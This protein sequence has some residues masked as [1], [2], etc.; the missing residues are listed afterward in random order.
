MMLENRPLGVSILVTTK[1]RFELSYLMI[2]IRKE[3]IENSISIALQLRKLFTES[4]QIRK[5]VASLA[6]SKS[7]VLISLTKEKRSSPE[8]VSIYGKVGI[9]TQANY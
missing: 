4:D 3:M 2:S 6:K 9:A 1:R 5:K 8:M 7:V